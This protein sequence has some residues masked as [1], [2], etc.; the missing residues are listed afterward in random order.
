MIVSR[1]RS[2]ASVVLQ[3]FLLFLFIQ[4]PTTLV[5]SRNNINDVVTPP[6]VTWGALCGPGIVTMSAQ[7]CE[8]G[9]IKWYDAYMNGNVVHTG[10][11]F[12]PY[13][14]VTT[15]YWVSCSINGVESARVWVRGTI[16]TVP[17]DPITLGDV[18]CGPGQVVLTALTGWQFGGYSWY[19]QPTGG[20]PLFG[21]QYYQYAPTISTTTTF[22]VSYKSEYS[23]MSNLPG[24]ETNRVP[25]TAVV[26]PLPAAPTTTGNSRI[27]PGPVTL[28]ASGCPGGILKWYNV[29]F[30]G[31]MLLG[32]GDN[33]SWN[34]N[35]T[36]NFWV[37]CTIDN[38]ES[39]ATEVVATMINCANSGLNVTIP[40]AFALPAGAEANTVYLGY[41]PA[42]SLNLLAN[43]QGGESPY[44]Y[45]WNTG[46]T[47]QS[48][49]VT[50]SGSQAYSITITD[51]N[52][53]TSTATKTVQVKDVR[54]GN[55]HEKVLICKIPPGNSS[56]VQNICISSDAVSEHLKNGSRLGSCIVN[57]TT[58]TNPQKRTGADEELSSVSIRPNPTFNHFVL[59]VSGSVAEKV[60]MKVFDQM[61]RL[62][63]NVLL[64]PGQ[65][66]L[67]GGEYI[68]GVYFVEISNKD[69]KQ[70]VRV[71]K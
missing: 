54:C 58:L 67:F 53:C 8:G 25:V 59:T 19:S 38:C 23:G 70:M 68:P 16:E 63:E 1:N 22:W 41:G 60:S 10:T 64:S 17:P 32:T 6:T 45:S 50:P 11:S 47:S 49:T 42:S 18:R 65:Q 15:S 31:R 7:G 56:N 9:T 13:L 26:K 52:G 12:A 36:M 69:R 48:I 5:F 71:V 29:P 34:I 39:A 20:S 30:P 4:L 40:N 55:R 21:S 62:I 35:G 51:K 2:H 57:S 28:Q 33:F 27:G 43:A 44:Q 46:A 66:I 14:N 37:T 61:G 24:C 3:F